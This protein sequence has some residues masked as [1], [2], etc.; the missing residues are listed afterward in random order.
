MNAG[1]IDERGAA[2]ARDVER[3][4][5]LFGGSAN[6][7]GA[8]GVVVF[9]IYLAP[10]TLSDAQI[11]EVAD[12]WPA[13][14]AYMAIT[15][16]LGWL[17]ITRR[18]FRPI[19]AWLRS[20]ERAD[21]AMQERVLRYPRNWALSAAVPWTGGA[22]LAFPLIAQVDVSV[23]AAGA[24]GIVAGG[25]TSCSLQYLAIEW[26]MRPVTARALAGG[27]PPGS[28]TPGVAAR[29]AMAWV[30]GSGVPLLGIVIFA[31]ADIVG[32]DFDAQEVAV[33]SL[34]LAALGILNGAI[35][36]MI[37]ARSVVDPLGS[38]RSALEKVERGE[39]STQVA[40]DDG[41]E[42]GL[43]EAGFNRMTR[44]L[45]ERERLRDAFGA[46]V[47]PSVAE[48]IVEEGT[49]LSGEQVELSLLFVDVRD[50]TG[51]AEQVGPHEVVACLNAL[52]D[53][54][55]P[56]V[57][58]CGGHA[59]KFIGDGLLAV[60]GAPARLDDHA[61]R[62]VKA[63]LEIGGLNGRADT[64]GLRVGVGVNTR[65]G[66][67][68]HD[69]RR[70]APR[71]HRHRRRREHGRPRRGR[72]AQDRRRRPDHGRHPR[73]PPRRPRRLDRARPGRDEG[74]GGTGPAVRAEPELGM[75]SG[76]DPK[77]VSIPSHH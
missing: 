77:P 64:D 47:D 61:D 43:L 46:Y 22:L 37:A 7:L 38:M 29:T 33:A 52:Y 28:G 8:S 3:R 5:A 36:T 39:L 54:V 16:P 75:G 17:F 51:F 1:A 58:G 56:I 59:N 41:S 68:R 18:P 45:A 53:R 62:A 49:D 35:A 27:P 15:L 31:A 66:R 70:R 2:R 30:F 23:A 34:V 13:F 48:R 25:L 19:A 26:I 69:R 12:I 50:F 76:P 73:A 42:V 14:V 6:L 10:N 71:L 74:E 11:E 20:G 67:G 4:L 40:V 21:V 44:G 65:R 63:A 9:L 24:L 32:A 72:H 57:T 55:V 60:F